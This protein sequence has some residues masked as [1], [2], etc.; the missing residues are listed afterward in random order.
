MHADSLFSSLVC[1]VVAS[2]VG[3]QDKARVNHCLGGMS[4]DFSDRNGGG[5]SGNH[6]SVVVLPEV[7]I[8]M[9]SPWSLWLLML[10]NKVTH[11]SCLC[12]E[13]LTIGAHVYGT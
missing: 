5:P 7:S 4:F 8:L 1:N 13:S 9:E 2:F 11:I 3:W 6:L 10:A 12:Q